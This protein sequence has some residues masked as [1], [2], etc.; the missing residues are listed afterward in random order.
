MAKYSGK[1]Y[2]VSYLKKP[3]PA[4]EGQAVRSAWVVVG[5]AFAV[6]DGTIAIRL[7]ALPM[8]GC[9]DGSLKLYP[10]NQEE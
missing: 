2:D 9:W 10:R 3:H 4:D 8:S 5:R 7:D 6:N 1:Q